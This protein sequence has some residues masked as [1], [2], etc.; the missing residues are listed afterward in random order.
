MKSFCK[1]FPVLVLITSN[2]NAQV[3]SPVGV[4]GFTLDAVAENT[5]ALATTSGALDGSDYILYSAAYAAIFSSGGGL[6]NN[7]IISNS[8]YTYQCQP[9]N[10]S[11]VFFLPLGQ[12]D[13]LVLITPASFSALSLLGFATEGNGTMN[14]T[15]R[16]TDNSTQAFSSV[17]LLDWFGGTSSVING[18]GR[19][20]RT[21]GNISLVSG[22]PKMFNTDLLLSCA[23]RSKLVKNIKVNN[24]SPNARVC[25][26]AL[27][28][29]GMPVY[30]ATS[31]PVSCIGGTN[32]TASLVISNPL[33]PNSYT[34]SSNP[35]Q[36]S[37][38]AQNLTSGVYSYTVKDAAGCAFSS[39][40][41][42]GISTVP[43]APLMIGSSSTL[44][45]PGTQLNLSTFG[46]V[47]YTWSNAANSAVNSVTPMVTTSY[48]VQGTTAANCIVSGA[49]T[50]SVFP[51]TNVS[52]TGLPN[53]F[54]V[55]A[56][57]F[58]LTG[59]PG[60]GNFSG[61][62]VS[63]GPVFVP[64]TGPGTYTITYQY[65][66]VNACSYSVSAT[67]QV[68]ALPQLSFALSPNVFCANAP[69]LSLN[70]SPSGGS[71]SG[72]GLIGSVFNP[73]LAGA[74]THSIVY[75]Y[76]DANTCSN[77]AVQT[78]TVNPLPLVNF[79][80]IASAYCKNAA[81]VTLSF[82]PSGGVL[83]GTGILNGT[84]FSP[85][86]AGVGSHTLTY[87]YTNAVTGCS[88]LASISTSVSACTGLSDMRD[89]HLSNFVV[90][91]NPAHL[92]IQ[93]T[94]DENAVIEIFDMQ[95]RLLIEREIK[96]NDEFV[97]NISDLKSG[98]YI[99]RIQSLSGHY[100]RKLLIE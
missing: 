28:G 80:P 49:I 87:V 53:A 45:C 12:T 30:T 68:F 3:F 15:V 25:F 86:L 11:N 41:S 81:P 17:S 20:G 69:S 36:V 9:Y 62:G 83:S 92:E 75:A 84:A 96:Q 44:I 50:I 5:T 73:S 97:L 16:F 79:T 90:Y 57:P 95:N 24:A 47:S 6:P 39:T 48:S 99:V 82:S 18:F 27:A 2:L 38:Q 46:A 32:G 74:G 78:L 33:P 34:W 76:T 13:S 8:N 1:L 37:G 14:L 52:F 42:V 35:V 63:A 71:F 60:G 19:A 64:A 66:D 58:P 56:A 91:P 4:T 100:T 21:S 7:G 43:L 29:A 85:N 26:M 40:V 31:T 10:Q 65:T 59:S 88:A 89:E 94:S 23:N 61:N 67:T 55:D 77:T 70:A 98:I 22:Q 51:I 54:C 93:I 72:P